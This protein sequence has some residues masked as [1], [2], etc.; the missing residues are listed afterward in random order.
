MPSNRGHLI[1][2]LGG[3]FTHINAERGLTAGALR[4]TEAADGTLL[5]ATTRGAGFRVRWSPRSPRSRAVRERSSA[6]RYVDAR[7]LPVRARPVSQS[8]RYTAIGS[9]RARSEDEWK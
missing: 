6:A 2:Y 7:S 4:L 9:H 5:L 8:G 3:R 1:R